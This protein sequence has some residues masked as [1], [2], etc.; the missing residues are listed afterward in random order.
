MALV[1]ALLP[2]IRQAHGRILW[3]A[4]PGM[5]AIPYVSSIHAPEFAMNCIAHSLHL[6]LMP[7][8][9]PN[10]LICCGGIKTPAADRTAQELEATVRSWSPEQQALYGQTMQRLQTRLARFDAGRSEP[11]VVGKAVFRALVARRPRRRY[12]VGS[13][14]RAM[15]MLR[16]LPQPVIDAIF[17]RLA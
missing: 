16:F 17:S 2:L 9:V 11:E 10:I 4:T 7:W 5:I 1:Q 12:A 6:E 14:A 3:I 13:G 15:N 8:K